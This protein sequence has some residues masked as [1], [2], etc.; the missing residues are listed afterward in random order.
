[1]LEVKKEARYLRLASV[2]PEFLFR[3]LSVPGYDPVIAG[4][5]D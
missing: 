1:V 5:E 2:Q 4:V 3:E